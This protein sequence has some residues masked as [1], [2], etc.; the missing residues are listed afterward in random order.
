[1]NPGLAIFDIEIDWKKCCKGK[2][3]NN[4]F[5]FML[6]GSLVDLYVLDRTEIPKTSELS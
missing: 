6:L 3:V 2:T 4:A 5:S 1:M